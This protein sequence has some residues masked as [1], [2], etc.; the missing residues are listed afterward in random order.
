[1]P[2]G[3]ELICCTFFKANFISIGFIKSIGWLKSYG[4]VVGGIANEWFLPSG[5]IS[6]GNVCHERGYPV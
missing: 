5:G 2:K 1:M 6:K 4:N 3:I